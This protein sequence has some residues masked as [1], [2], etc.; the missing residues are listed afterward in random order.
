METEI[1]NEEVGT[2]PLPQS[3]SD[4]SEAE[5]ERLREEIRTL[6]ESIAEKQAQTEKISAELG[7]FAEYFPDVELK[8]IPEEVW[9]EVKS[10]NSLAASYALY[11]HKT[12]QSERIM[13]EQNEKNAY[14]SAGRV[15]KNTANEYFTP[16]D[17]K[18]MSGSEVKANYS[19]I[20][21]SMKKWN[22]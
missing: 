22:R 20:I 12:K 11:T 3:A 2:E 21:A 16:D 8:S 6:N 15:G 14:F 10:G 19:K 18:K 7:A 5:L 4:D 13:R 9:N 17:V 1:S